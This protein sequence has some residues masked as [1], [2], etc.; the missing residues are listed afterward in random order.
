L[1][2]S[3]N[4]NLFGIFDVFYISSYVAA[5]DVGD[6]GKMESCNVI[7]NESNFLC[8]SP[9]SL[10]HKLVGSKLVRQAEQL[11]VDVY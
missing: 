3:I 7:R 11:Y 4:Y 1:L 5:V 2:V 10:K 8:L 6:A 9:T